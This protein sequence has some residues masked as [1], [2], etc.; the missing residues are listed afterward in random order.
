MFLWY[1]KAGMLP[2]QKKGTNIWT[3]FWNGTWQTKLLRS[4]VE[5]DFSQGYEP[6]L[7]FRPTASY[8]VADAGFEPASLGHEPSKEPL[9]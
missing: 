6:R 2:P 8:I 7:D 5:L 9:L 1:K 3:S 4:R